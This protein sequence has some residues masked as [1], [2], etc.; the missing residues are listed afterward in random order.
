MNFIKK[1]FTI[2]MKERK[3]ERQKKEEMTGAKKMID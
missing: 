3:K 1:K 2:I